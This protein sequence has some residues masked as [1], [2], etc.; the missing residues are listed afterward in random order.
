MKSIFIQGKWAQARGLNFERRSPISSESTYL[1]RSSSAADVDDAVDYA[2]TNYSQWSLTSLESRI[3]IASRFA[4]LL[5]DQKEVLARL[6]RDE[7]GKPL[8]ESKLEVESTAA[9]VD[10]SI[11]AIHERQKPSETTSY[12]PYG[13]AAVIGP[14]NF[15]MHLP[16]AQIIP[17]LLAGNVV[18]YKPSE[19][20]PAVAEAYTRIWL[21]AGLP[22]FALQLLQGDG[23]VAELLV[24][25]KCIKGI[26]FTG[27]YETGQKIAHSSLSV[28]GR[29]V[30]LEMGG[31]NPL[32]VCPS[33]Q[34]PTG[35]QISAISAFI[36]SGQRCTCARRLIVLENGATDSFLQLLIKA[37]L[38]CKP[39]MP[40]DAIDPFLGPLASE[41][42]YKR[43]LSAWSRLVES[44]GQVLLSL[45]TLEKTLVTPAI[46]DMT[47]G[48][49]FDEEI[50][51]PI[52]QVFRASSIDQAI[53]MANNTE[54]GLAAG[55]LSLE[56]TEWEFIFPRLSAGIINWNCSTIGASGKSPFGGVGKSG[57]CRP[58][59]FFACD[60]AA[61]PVAT[62]AHSQLTLPKFIPNG[63]A[64]K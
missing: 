31:N 44:N 20:A 15:P 51:G 11:A 47:N 48:Q 40:S 26:Y 3:A 6:I 37:A 54:Y 28:P 41:N 27:S 45:D 1:G 39:G 32:I 42:G 55:V 5:L 25:H 63:M 21:D 52:L 22:P 36:T 23:K 19:L 56:K 58:A 18:L 13:I 10:L 49:P 8:W 33:A 57:N 53:E 17:A 7:I 59:G 64:G 2:L 4:K 14:F 16:N 35:A 61:Y 62:T 43:V 46:I 34:S 30:A 9:K 24:Q 50:F 38:S 29:I 60:S 12:R